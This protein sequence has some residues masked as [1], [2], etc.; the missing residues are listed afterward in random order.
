MRWVCLY[1]ISFIY[2]CQASKH[3]TDDSWRVLPGDFIQTWWIVWCFLTPPVSPIKCEEAL[4]R[5]VKDHL[6]I[7]MFAQK[8]VMFEMELEITKSHKAYRYLKR[9]L[10]YAFHSLLMSQTNWPLIFGAY[11]FGYIRFNIILIILSLLIILYQ[12]FVPTPSGTLNWD[13]SFTWESLG[14]AVTDST[15]WCNSLGLLLVV[16]YFQCGI[17]NFT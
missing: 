2:S 8:N 15:G 6:Y 11:I 4:E 16:K 14:L 10:H 12:L 17:R 3:I 9:L 7:V 13:R 1:E 5:R